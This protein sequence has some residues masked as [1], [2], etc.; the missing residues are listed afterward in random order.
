MCRATD[1]VLNLSM[2]KT[3]CKE[4]LGLLRYD[5]EDVRVYAPTA[6]GH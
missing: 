3:V 5:Y 6:K 1:I 2:Q 4:K